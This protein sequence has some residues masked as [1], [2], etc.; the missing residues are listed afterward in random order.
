MNTKYIFTIALKNS[1]KIGRAPDSVRMISYNAVRCPDGHRPML[2]YKTPAGTRT[3]CDH[4]R[5]NS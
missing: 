1:R 2:S 3:I 5:E 4:A